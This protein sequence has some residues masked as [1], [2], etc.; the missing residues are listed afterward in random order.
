[1][2][3][4]SRKNSHKQLTAVHYQSSE[5][6]E[7]WTWGIALAD[8]PCEATKQPPGA[9]SVFFLYFSADRAFFRGIFGIFSAFSL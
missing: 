4:S 8:A 1:V 9:F 6:G 2:Q 7:K 5:M 3:T